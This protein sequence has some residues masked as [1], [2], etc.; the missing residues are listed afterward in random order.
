MPNQYF[1]VKCF[2]IESPTVVLSS[3]FYCF[4]CECISAGIP[5]WVQEDIKNAPKIY[6]K[7][8]GA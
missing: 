5:Q 8:V 1:C 7:K 6:S 3:R 2:V 4:N